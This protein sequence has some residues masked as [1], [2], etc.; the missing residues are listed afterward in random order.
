MG[1]GKEAG[2][3]EFDGEKR[4]I[5]RWIVEGSTKKTRESR[6]LEGVEI[7]VDRGK[8]LGVAG[9]ETVRHFRE[10]VAMTQQAVL[11]LRIVEERK[12]VEDGGDFSD[13]SGNNITRERD[14]TDGC[15]Q[16]L[17]TTS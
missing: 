10:G 5:A 8:R 4:L 14:V 17:E 1:G 3:A 12:I 16:E 15:S 2:A 13:S 9:T 7:V 6:E 11:Q